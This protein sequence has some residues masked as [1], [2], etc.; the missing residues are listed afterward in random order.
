V[1]AVTAP[2][3][4]NIGRVGKSFLTGQVHG[5]WFTHFR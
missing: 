3:E 1:F 2:D 4:L 5:R